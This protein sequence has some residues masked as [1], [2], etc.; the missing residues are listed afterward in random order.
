LSP[1]WLKKVRSTAVIFSLKT[2]HVFIG[3]IIF[4]AI[5]TY[6]TPFSLFQNISIRVV[7]R[8]VSN[9]QISIQYPPSV[10][11]ASSCHYPGKTGAYIQ[12]QIQY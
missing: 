6:V 7:I 3:N 1:G 5:T 8:M 9:L 4:S 10:C 11:L 2:Q 12:T